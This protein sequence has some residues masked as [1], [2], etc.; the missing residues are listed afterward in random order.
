MNSAATLAFKELLFQHCVQ[1]LTQKASALKAEIV[2]LREGIAND[3]K[4]SMGDK[5]ETS[6]EMSQQEI[7]RLEQQLGLIGQQQFQLKSIAMK[8]EMPQIGFGSLVATN[9]GRFFISIALGEIKIDTENIFV[10]SPASPIGKLMIGK[11]S[12]ETFKMNQKQVEII[13][14]Y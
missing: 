5:Y 10:I 14:F 13:E 4:S 6:R 12:G 2:Q 11:Q 8:S 3:S 9:I 1:L 7:N